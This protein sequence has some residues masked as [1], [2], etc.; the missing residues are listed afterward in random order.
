MTDMELEDVPVD[1]REEEMKEEE[2][3]IEGKRKGKAKIEKQTRVRKPNKYTEEWI[4]L[5]SRSSN[6]I[7]SNDHIFKD[8]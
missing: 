8:P 4:K 7:S 2:G 1:E 6:A 5:L 3:S